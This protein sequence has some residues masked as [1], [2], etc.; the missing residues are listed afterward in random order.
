MGIFVNPKNCR[1]YGEGGQRKDVSEEPLETSDGDHEKYKRSQIVGGL[2][3]SD[4]DN[5]PAG[6]PR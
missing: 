1:E 2:E 3:R 5:P 4:K 6:I